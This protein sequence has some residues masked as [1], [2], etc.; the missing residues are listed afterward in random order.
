M[1]NR[2]TVIKPGLVSQPP[3]MIN[4]SPPGISR[5]AFPNTGGGSLKIMAGN[6]TVLEV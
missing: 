1:G 4:H 6:E 5:S 2:M 3:W